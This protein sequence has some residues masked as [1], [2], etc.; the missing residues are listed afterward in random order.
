MSQQPAPTPPPSPT[1]KY[2]PPAESKDGKSVRID[3]YTGYGAVC[4]MYDAFKVPKLPGDG[5]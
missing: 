5:R 4:A 3:F 2:T 1:W